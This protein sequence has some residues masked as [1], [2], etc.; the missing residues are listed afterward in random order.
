MG[1]YAYEKFRMEFSADLQYRIAREIGMYYDI[2][3]NDFD[4]TVIDLRV[5][6][7]DMQQRYRFADTV[8]K[9][10]TY[11]Q[12]LK[13][14]PDYDK[15]KPVLLTASEAAE[16][17]GRNRKTIADWNRKGLLATGGSGKIKRIDVEKTIEKLKKSIKILR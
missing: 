12:T 10:E 15:D 16:I 17:T 11:L 2:D 8:R 3:A 14:E 4:W 9:L 7:A 13:A 1:R 5:K 6:R